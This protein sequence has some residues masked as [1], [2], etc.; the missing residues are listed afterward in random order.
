[1]NAGVTYQR[2]DHCDERQG[3]SPFI[4]QELDKELVLF[5]F[6]L[7]KISPKHQWDQGG[8]ERQFTMRSHLQCISGK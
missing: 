2:S 4:F 5:R 8:S 7:D 1:M 6:S 3:N